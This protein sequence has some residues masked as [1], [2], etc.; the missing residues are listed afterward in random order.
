MKKKLLNVIASIEARLKKNTLSEDAQ[1]LWEEVRAAFEALANDTAEHDITEL[2]DQF[3]QIAAKFAASDE[4]VA[5]RVQTL[6]NEIIG[7]LNAGKTAKDKLTPELAHSVANAIRESRSREEVRNRV[8]AILKENGITGL[9]YGYIIDYSLDLK[10][11]DHE[12]LYD[13]LHK[14][15]FSRFIYA[16]VDRTNAAQIAK[17]WNKTSEQDKA[18]QE[19]EANDR[20]IDTKYV[21]KRQAFAQEDLD[22]IEDA[23]QLQEFLATISEELRVLCKTGIVDAILMGDT[24]NAAGDKITTFETIGTKAASDAFTSVLTSSDADVAAFISG[25]G[26]TSLQSVLL[27]SAKLAVSRLWNPYNKKVVLAMHK[28]VLTIMS[29]YVVAGGGD[30]TFRT[31][32]E[33]AAQ[34]GV[35]EIYTAECMPNDLKTAGTYPIFVAFM[36]DGYWVKEKKA[37][38]IAYPQPWKNVQNMQYEINCGGKLHDLLSSAVFNFVVK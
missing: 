22:E 32:E 30:V 7:M 9:S 18:I 8:E 24:I 35:D 12:G 19:L 36:P 3:E 15:K 2:K 14:T 23:G 28:D 10:K 16:E 25:I 29:A 4:A 20:T 27:A 17:Q 33:I 38:D 6:R 37:L 31:R 21:Y 11:E 5:E 26:A 1:A 13:S 34:I